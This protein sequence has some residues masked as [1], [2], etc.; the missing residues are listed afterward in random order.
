LVGID[1]I[2]S[3]ISAFAAA[4]GLIYSTL[5]YKTSTN[6]LR[7]TTKNEHFKTIRE[8]SNEIESLEK[9]K[10]INENH[11][12]FTQLYLNYVERL[13]YM[14]VKDLIDKDIVRYFVRIFEKALGL[15]E[16]REYSTYRHT[17]NY[18][19]E[20]CQKEFIQPS[21]PPLPYPDVQ[22]IKDSE[23][24]L[25]KFHPST[26]S[27]EISAMVVW[28]NNDTNHHSVTFGNGPSDSRSGKEFN[29]ETMGPLFELKGK[30]SLFY[31]IFT[32]PGEFP[33]YCTKHHDEKGVV[34]VKDKQQPTIIGVA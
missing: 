2:I 28:K 6:E 1:T 5:Q 19:M 26:F 8:F 20:W 10:N 23:N 22:I 25:A 9:D 32:K 16:M 7:H 29:S 3:A 24:T 12:M 17:L 15:L 14:G 30:D 34:I 27:A 31:H 4:A 13:A 21:S 18:L 11:K 33:Y